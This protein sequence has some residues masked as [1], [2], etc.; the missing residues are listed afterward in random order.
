MADTEAIDTED[1]TE[2]LEAKKL[3]GKKLVLIGGGVAVVI[4]IALVA[5]LFLGGDEEPAAPTGDE[6]LDRLSEAAAAQNAQAAPVNEELKT[7]FIEIPAQQYNLNTGGQ[8][9]Q[10]LLAE[11]TLEVDRESFKADIEEKLP[12]ILD[13]FNIYMRELHPEDV[14]GARG[15]LHVKTELLSRI[16][17]SVAPSRVRDVLFQK[18]IIQS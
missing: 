16:N 6:E 9:R 1:L 8:G 13:E 18:F 14:T 4:I 10:Y 3:S 17:Q 2:G 15:L 12:R 11:I 7:L 5:F